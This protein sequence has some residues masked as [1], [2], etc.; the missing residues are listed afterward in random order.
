MCLMNNFS[1]LFLT[2]TI[3]NFKRPL[4]LTLDAIFFINFHWWA[5]DRHSQMYSKEETHRHTHTHSKGR[6]N[7]IVTAREGDMEIRFNR[8]LYSADDIHF[9]CFL[10][11]YWVVV[12]CG[13]E[14]SD[15]VC[16]TRDILM[17]IKCMMCMYFC[18][19]LFTF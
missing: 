9:F 7:E 5:G 19:V 8:P 16:V 2:E 14:P 11:S 12:L 13:K 15:S 3:P 17:Q 18:V 10:F 1:T 6:E 4:K